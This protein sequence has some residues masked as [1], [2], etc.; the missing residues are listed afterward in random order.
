MAAR[1]GNTPAICR[2]CYVHPEVF[3]AWQAGELVLQ[4]QPDE[5]DESAGLR[6]DEAAVLALLKA[7]LARSVEG[8][9]ARSLAALG[10][11]QRARPGGGPHAPARLSICPRRPSQSA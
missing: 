11:P 4:V 3:A 7:R 9:L 2:K 6:P 10:R 1:L 8:D 5:P